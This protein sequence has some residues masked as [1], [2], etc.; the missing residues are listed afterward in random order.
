MSSTP[1]GYRVSI[2]SGGITDAERCRQNGW[3]VGTVLEGDE[4]YGPDR[5]IITAI[6]ERA[7]LARHLSP[8]GYESQWGL[9]ARDW[10][11]VSRPAPV[12]EAGEGERP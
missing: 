1:A 10:K 6:G 7:V 11:A 5:I 9:H 2:T 12:P 3:E 8:G 4:G